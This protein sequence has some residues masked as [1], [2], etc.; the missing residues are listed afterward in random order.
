MHQIIGLIMDEVQQLSPTDCLSVI[1]GGDFYANSHQIE[2]ALL[3]E[4]LP[5][6]RDAWM[7]Q[8]G[9]AAGYQYKVG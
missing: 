4:L 8:R 9:S 3:H 1:L 7:V 2:M 5:G 6:L